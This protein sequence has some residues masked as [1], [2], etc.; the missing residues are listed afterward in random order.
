MRSLS[1]GAYS[2]DPL[3]RNDGIKTSNTLGSSSIPAEATRRRGIQYNRS[4]PVQ[5][6]T[7]LE[8]WIARLRGR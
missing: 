6:V 3:A 5:Q 8:Y 4:F 7:S 2:R 1:P